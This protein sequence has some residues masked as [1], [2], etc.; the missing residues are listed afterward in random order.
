MIVHKSTAS[1]HKSTSSFQTI[2]ATGFDKLLVAVTKIG[3]QKKP[4]LFIRYQN[5]K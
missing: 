5:Y 2:C 3:L 4:S 1:S